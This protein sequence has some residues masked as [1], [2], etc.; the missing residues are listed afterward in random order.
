MQADT[1]YTTARRRMGTYK[2]IMAE[3]A[4]SYTH[5]DLGT[6]SN[7]YYKVR[8]YY[9]LDNGSTVYSAW[10]SVKKLTA[11]YAIMAQAA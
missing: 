4:T 11:G 1:S 2:K 8:A 6:G 5:T 9:L 7:Y 3:D 10:S